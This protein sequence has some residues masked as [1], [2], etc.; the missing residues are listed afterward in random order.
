MRASFCICQLPFPE[1]AFNSTTFTDKIDLIVSHLSVFIPER[2][3]N[4]VN[5]CLS[6]SKVCAYW[7]LPLLND[8]RILQ[9]AWRADST[10]RVRFLGGGL[11]QT[12]GEVNVVEWRREGTGV[13]LFQTYSSVGT[14]WIVSQTPWTKE[15]TCSDSDAIS[16]QLCPCY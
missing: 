9:Q 11:E 7:A 15:L 4:C 13:R 1:V 10:I 6:Q 8:Q 16:R 12:F 5:A 14:G 2:G 3:V